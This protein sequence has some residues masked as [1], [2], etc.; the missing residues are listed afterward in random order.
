LRQE[1]Q[2]SQ[3]I[4]EHQSLRRHFLRTDFRSAGL[5][6]IRSIHGGMLGIASSRAVAAQAAA[7][8]R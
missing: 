5:Q 4:T 2:Q 7:L 1:Q 8:A 6:A 3:Q